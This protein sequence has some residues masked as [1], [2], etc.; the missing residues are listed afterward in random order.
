MLM[1]IFLVNRDRCCINWV[2]WGGFRTLASIC[3][4]KHAYNEPFPYIVPPCDRLLCQA[5][6]RGHPYSCPLA[7]R[8]RQRYLPWFCRLAQHLSY[9]QGIPLK[10]KMQSLRKPQV[11]ISSKLVSKDQFFRAKAK[12]QNRR[13]W[14]RNRLCR[15]DQTKIGGCQNLSKYSDLRKT[16]DLGSAD[17]FPICWCKSG[18]ILDRPLICLS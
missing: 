8:K 15:T 1:I 2:S 17:F 6:C 11:D 10:G 5:S 9:H 13:G 7:T 18:S 4:E 16:A 3:I 12:E 14:G